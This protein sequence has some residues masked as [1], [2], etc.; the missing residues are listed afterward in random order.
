[1]FRKWAEAKAVEAAPGA[2]RRT[3]AVGE[4]TLLV[5]WTILKGGEVVLHNHE[6]EQIGY[7]I[8]GAIDMTIA[9]ETQRLAPGDGYV[10]PGGTMHG[11][12]AVEDSRIVDVF[13]PARKDYAD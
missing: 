2:T 12:V 7:L 5:E 13:H 4:K 10:A 9:G 1:L 8:S 11:A 3:L 6:Y